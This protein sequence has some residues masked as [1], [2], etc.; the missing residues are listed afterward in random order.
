MHEIKPSFAVARV[1]FNRKIFL[2]QKI[3]IRFKEGTSVAF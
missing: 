2:H 1:A 3:G